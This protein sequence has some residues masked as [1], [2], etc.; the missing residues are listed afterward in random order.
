M[1]LMDPWPS[2]HQST[3]KTSLYF[4]TSESKPTRNGIFVILFFT[5]EQRDTWGLVTFWWSI[6]LLFTLAELPNQFLTTSLKFLKF[7]WSDCQPNLPSWILVSSSFPKS[8]VSFAVT[9]LQDFQLSTKSF[10]PWI[11]SLERKSTISISTVYF[12]KWYYPM[13]LTIF[14]IDLSSKFSLRPLISCII[15]FLQC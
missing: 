9:E 10:I 15:M 13:L 14:W 11:K 6:M 1:K 4:S 3:P 12:L 5:A 2:W 8:K 7:V